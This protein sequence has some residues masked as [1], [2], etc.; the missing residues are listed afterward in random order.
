MDVPPPF[1]IGRRYIFG[2]VGRKGIG[3]ILCIP[4]VNLFLL[5]PF[6]PCSISIVCFLDYLWHVWIANK[7]GRMKQRFDLVQVCTIIINIFAVDQTSFFFIFFSRIV[8]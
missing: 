6:H 7:A 5:I 1:L 2:V 4:L 8:A 3:S